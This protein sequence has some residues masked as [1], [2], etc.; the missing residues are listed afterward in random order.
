MDKILQDGKHINVIL[1]DYS[2]CASNYTGT[3]TWTKEIGGAAAKIVQHLAHSCDLNLKSVECVGFGFGAHICGT[4]SS[5]L[6]VKNKRIVGK[7]VNH[8]IRI[9]VPTGYTM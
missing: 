1:V 6:T 9:I 3:V 8:V 5:K 7:L 4:F 2:P